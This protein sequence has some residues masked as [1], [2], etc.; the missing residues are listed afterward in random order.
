MREYLVTKGLSDTGI[1]ATSK[2]KFLLVYYTIVFIT[3][4]QDI[5]LFLIV[6]IINLRH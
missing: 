4:H 6:Y 2:E 1:E 3:I 5:Q